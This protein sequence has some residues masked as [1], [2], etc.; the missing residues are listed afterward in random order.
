MVGLQ[1]AAMRGALS[2]ERIHVNR[3]P[4]PCRIALGE[5]ACRSN[6]ASACGL[7]Q[8]ITATGL[9]CPRGGSSLHN[10]YRTTM[11]ALGIMGVT[12]PA[13]RLTRGGVGASIYSRR[14]SVPVTTMSISRLPHLEQIS[15]SRQSGTVISA[16]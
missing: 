6:T 8:P 5:L 3:R 9:Q 11:P 14:R 1:S 10:R 16:P 2:I 15:R 13:E 7:T 12:T 4:P